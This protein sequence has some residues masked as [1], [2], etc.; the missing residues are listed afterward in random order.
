M[1]SLSR[2]EEQLRESGIENAVVMSAI[3]SLQK[4]RFH[5]VTGTG[6]VAEDEYLDMEKPIELASLQGVVINGKPHPHVTFGSMLQRTIYHYWYHNG[7][8][9]AIRQMLGHTGLPDFVG[10]I[11]SEAPYRPEE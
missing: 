4:A 3:G 6:E 9:Q 11:D 8:N 10:D 1:A 5:R 2:Y 7:E